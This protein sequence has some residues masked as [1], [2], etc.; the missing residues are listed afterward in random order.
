MAC[1]SFALP[2]MYQTGID[3][4]V[5]LSSLADLITDRVIPDVPN[6]STMGLTRLKEE[7]G[8]L[9]VMEGRSCVK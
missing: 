5:T 9:E 6:E 8:G 1:S 7:F 3:G 4:S 2:G